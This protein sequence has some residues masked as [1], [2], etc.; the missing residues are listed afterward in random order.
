MF[1]LPQ[2]DTDYLIRQAW[3]SY[4]H[5]RYEWFQETI[6]KPKQIFYA[7]NVESIQTGL[8]FEFRVSKPSKLDVK[9]SKFIVARYF[10]LIYFF[11]SKYVYYLHIMPDKR[12]LVT[13]D[14]CF[15]SEIYGL[16]ESFLS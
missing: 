6:L 14:I 11:V 4:Y 5:L 15:G 16:L 13:S 9:E 8:L 10:V 12:R 1:H 2:I 7:S 3:K